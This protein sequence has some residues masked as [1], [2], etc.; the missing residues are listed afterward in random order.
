M[1]KEALLR[2]ELEASRLLD[3]KECETDPVIFI[4]RHV[5]IEDPQGRVLP[6][7]L[8]PFQ[9]QTVTAL[10]EDRQ[11]VV[12]KARRLGLSWLFLAY[13]LWLAIFNQGIRI[14]VL[15]K[16]EGD[17]GELL[18]RIR[19]IR[20]RIATDPASA[21]ILAGLRKPNK[22]RDAVTTLDIGESTIRALV[23]TPAAA[24]S[25]TAGLVILDEFAFQKRAGKIWRALIPTIDGGGKVGVISTGDGISGDA[26]E[27]ANQWSRASSGESGFTPLFWPWDARP[28]RDQAWREK[29]VGLVGGEERFQVEY[30]EEPD[31]AFQ[32]PDSTMVFSRE[33]IDAAEKLGAKLDSEGA[34]DTEGL[35][36]G[37]DWGE[38]TTSSVVGWPLERGG[39]Y[40][41]TGEL[42]L[43][44]TEP[45][46]ATSQMLAS[47]ANHDPP[48]IEARYDA[49]GA[50]SMR[51]FIAQSPD[52][53]G[54]WKVAFSKHKEA[55]IG[56]LR[57][58][59][60]RTA[61]G[62]ETRVIAISPRNQVLLRQL[63]SYELDQKTGKP[64]K[65][66]DHTVDALIALT[67]PV[68]ERHQ[69]M[70]R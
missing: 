38:H 43:H 54:I 57:Q 25:E 41:P 52:S 36:L 56:Y 66:D 11:V 32:R 28:D 50:Q 37:I 34:P 67:A 55:T 29:T 70:I 21:H 17:A 60:E 22:V 1:N 6:F 13:A 51:T 10:H 45:A 14:L 3:L 16:N 64:R 69:E 39:V 35:Y 19:R 4:E 8:W 12:L 44:G 33:G 68:A 15:C 23:G 24:R 61:A 2:A 63:R 62:K 53:I 58:L 20:D 7:H 59:F 47:A 46:A 27:F 5:S 31:Q 30:P 40:V 26:E 48:L 18:D 65:G 49:A 9:A 42:E